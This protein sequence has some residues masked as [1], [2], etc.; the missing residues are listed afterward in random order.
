MNETELY[1]EDRIGLRWLSEQER[2]VFKQ[3]EGEHMEFS[4]GE[5]EDQLL[6][7]LLERYRWP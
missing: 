2:V 4:W 5:F 6:P 3:I 1:L 7:Y